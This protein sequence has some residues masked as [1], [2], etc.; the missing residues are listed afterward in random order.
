VH[1]DFL[2]F[3]AIVFVVAL[4]GAVFM[5][6]AWYASLK[7]PSWTPPDW[8]FAPAWTTLYLMIAI[9]GW[10]VWR[11]EDIG[12][13]LV[14]WGLNLVFNALWSWLMF[15]R[16]RIGLA[17][18]DAMAMLITIVGFIVF[19]GSSSPTAALLFVPYLAWVGFATALNF[20]LLQR[21]PTVR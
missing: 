10:L 9:A 17:L 21:N 7:K 14:M 19:T 16:H 4:S 3:L 15:G 1:L 12:P 13:A 20:A 8:L 5:P 18:A 2:P 6:G 11:A